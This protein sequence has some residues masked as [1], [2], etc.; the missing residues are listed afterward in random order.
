MVYPEVRAFLLKR[1]PL[2][3]KHLFV[4]EPSMM[5]DDHSGGSHAQSV[6]AKAAKSSR[7]GAKNVRQSAQT[8]KVGR[9]KATANSAKTRSTAKRKTR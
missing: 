8:A 4:S 5:S 7:T 1:Q 2:A 9:A 3:R 6:V